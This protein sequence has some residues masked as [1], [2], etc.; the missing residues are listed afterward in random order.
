MEG[1][2]VARDPRPLR[3]AMVPANRRSLVPI[4]GC[5][6]MTSPLESPLDQ[7]RRTGHLNRIFVDGNWTRPAGAEGVPLVCPSTGATLAELP[8]GDTCDV[9]RAV[10]AARRAFPGWSATSPYERAA[11]LGRMHALMLERAE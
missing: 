2:F 7:L 6:A 10:Q 3:Q 8:L 1:L 9:E 5:N 11:H 4:Q